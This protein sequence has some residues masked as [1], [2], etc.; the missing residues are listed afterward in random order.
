M[1]VLI[2]KSVCICIDRVYRVVCMYIYIYI[3]RERVY[4]YVSITVYK[5]ISIQV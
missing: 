5:Y 1:S 2:V 3:E 4:K